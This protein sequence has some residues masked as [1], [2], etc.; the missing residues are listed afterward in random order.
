MP[1]FFNCESHIDQADMC[2]RLREISECFSGS[3]VYFFGKQ[4]NVVAKRQEMI[5]LSFDQGEF[6]SQSHLFESPKAAD[7]KCP[8]VA[9]Q[10]INTGFIAL[11]QPV[12]P[13]SLADEVVG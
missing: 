4:A 12:L 7:P 8:F 10:S 9:T 6:A 13:Q 1:C 11:K 5:E 3:G 2:E